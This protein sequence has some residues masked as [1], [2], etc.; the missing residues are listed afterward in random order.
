MLLEVST[1]LNG[2]LTPPAYATKGLKKEDR[3]VFN[4]E[5]INPAVTL[6][7]TTTPD[8]YSRITQEM[9]TDGFLNRFIVCVTDEKMKYLRM[10]GKHDVPESIINWITAINDRLG[11]IEEIATEEPK[12]TILDISDEATEV[13]TKYEHENVDRIN[14]EL[15]DSPLK[16]LLVRNTELS[17]RLS[18]IVALAKD[19]NATTIIKSDAQWAVDWVTYN[20]EITL[21][22]LQRN[23]ADSPF[24]Q[25][26]MKWLQAFRAAGADGIMERDLVKKKPF[27]AE[28]KRVRKELI[29]D[30]MSSDCIAED[31]KQTGGRGR[32]SKYYYAI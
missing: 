13:F 4:D 29:D 12:L 32:P 24:E 15:A 1:K 27:S 16:E 26:R 17:M 20:S 23:M 10:I 5:V 18:L 9:V 21:K 8:I 30:L 31:V 25:K 7:A 22:H 28:E 19:P 11:N 3:K 2:I 14:G 6:L